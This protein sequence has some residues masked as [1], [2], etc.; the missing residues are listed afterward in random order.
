MVLYNNSMEELMK[1]ITFV[2]VFLNIS[3]YIFS[4]NNTSFKYGNVFSI[5]IAN[6]NYITIDDPEYRIEKMYLDGNIS[7][8]GWSRNGHFAYAQVL[9]KYGYYND[10][11]VS[12]VVIFNII[13]D[14]II[15]IVNNLKYYSEPSGGGWAE[16][17]E[18]PFDEF[19]VK[20]REEIIAS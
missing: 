14:E 1:K 15:N 5:F 19:W 18:I 6:D 11:P 17:D 2:I 20:Y 12:Q 16:A 7:P 4:Q 13:D 3:V 8:I 10:Y 9:D